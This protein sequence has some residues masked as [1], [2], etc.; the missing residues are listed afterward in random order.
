MTRPPWE[1]YVI[2]GIGEV[3]GLPADGFVIMLKIHHSAADGIA[4]VELLKKLHSPD[5]NSQPPP[6]SEDW[7]SEPYP[8]RQQVWSNALR[9]AARRPAKMIEIL[10]KVVPRVMEARRNA[11]KREEAQPGV[12]TRFNTR[13]SSQRVVDAVIL[14]LDRVKGIR[15]A[16]KGVSVNDVILSVV[17]GAL[18]KY[19]LAK[20][21]LPDTPITA[22]QAV[23]LRAPEEDKS[24]GNKVGIMRVSLATD[25]EDS[26]ERLRVVAQSNREAKERAA[27]MGTR[28]IMDLVESMGPLLVGAGVKLQ[29]LG[30]ERSS[31][32]LP[33]Q[34]GVTNIPGPQAALYMAGARLHMLMC[35]VPLMDGM[36]LANCVMSCAD[37]ITI[38]AVGCRELLP[39]PEFYRECLQHAWDALESAA[40]A[41]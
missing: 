38:T 30:L 40:G 1:A 7:K 37:K 9:N 2:E 25:V 23:S 28:E 27:A 35:M 17:G 8:T 33:Y 41:K 39:D 12:R 10:R 18:R 11:S 14:D 6:V 20:G 19:L 15:R 36:G 24:R 13:I 4:V 31:H 16:V 22:G 5:E 34:A 26:L 21:E 29:G 32:A 3:E